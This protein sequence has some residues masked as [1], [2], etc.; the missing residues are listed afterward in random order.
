MLD[1]DL[2][3]AYGVETRALVQAVKRNPDRFPGDFAFRLTNQEVARLRSQSVIFKVGGRNPG[4]R[5]FGIPWAFTEHGAVMAANLLRSPAAIDMSIH[6][7]RA[8]VRTRRALAAHAEL[9]DELRKLKRGLAAK[10]GQYDEQFRVVFLAIEQLIS[11]P[12]PNRP[13]IGFRRDDD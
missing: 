3:R 2:A 11:P 6:V 12:E 7:A 9:A 5:R 10:F 13:K 4:G 1:S 8:F